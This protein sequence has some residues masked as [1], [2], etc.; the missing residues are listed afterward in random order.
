MF[1]IQGDTQ[2]TLPDRLIFPLTGNLSV[3]HKGEKSQTDP[4][5]KAL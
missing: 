1:L 2:A 4:S 5:L 3:F